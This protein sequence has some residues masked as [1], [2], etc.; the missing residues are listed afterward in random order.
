[1]STPRARWSDAEKKAVLDCYGVAT[2][3]DDFFNLLKGTLGASY[4]RR[5]AKAYL[6]FLN[7]SLLPKTD[8][9][10]PVYQSLCE[11]NQKEIA[12]LKA[13]EE[14][15]KLAAATPTPPVPVS[16]TPAAP[17]PVT[18]AVLGPV[19]PTP[20]TPVVVDGPG[21]E[22]LA[23][24]DPYNW[25]EKEVDVVPRVP[26][27]RAAP[28]SLFKDP[29]ADATLNGGRLPT[30]NE[31]L[32]AQEAEAFAAGATNRRVVGDYLATEEGR[33]AIA[34]SMV[35]PI[36]GV[37]ARVSTEPVTK[38]AVKPDP[39]AL[40]P[41]HY[42]ALPSKG[43]LSADDLAQVFG[44]ARTKVVDAI[45]FGFIPSLDG[46]TVRHLIA[47][48]IH[49]AMSEGHTFSE[50]C[51]LVNPNSTGLLPMEALIEKVDPETAADDQCAEV[52]PGFDAGKVT[53]QVDAWEVSGG[54]MN[55]KSVAKMAADLNA[56]GPP[57]TVEV[58]SGPPSLF[59][60]GEVF[61]VAQSVEVASEP[62][63]TVETGDLFK[64]FPL[65][66]VPLPERGAWA[67]AYDKDFMVPSVSK[68]GVPNG[69]EDVFKD[70]TATQVP[71]GAF[72]QYTLEAVRDGVI[73][74]AQGLDIL[75][76]SDTTKAL[77]AL[78]LLASGKITVVQCDR[79]L[80]AKSPPAPSAHYERPAGYGLPIPSQK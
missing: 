51:R 20:P 30:L 68:T 36:R 43:A 72:E 61:P 16:I 40:V 19:V 58:L 17:D 44:L 41:R 6:T 45:T 69:N 59:Q 64:E 57:T 75:N 31:A 55:P 24:S 47:Q 80:F 5:S 38:P 56:K 67:A 14:A 26:P 25:V 10:R 74:T 79:L 46:S 54:P 15:A 48:S 9:R 12:A 11:A 66:E 71:S 53:L 29:Q 49:D 4:F 34:A 50:A 39:T 2:N 32:A 22:T 28:P 7:E 62:A 78:S 35:Q 3:A 1:M 13:A 42:P 60:G 33:K 18:P 63:K 65:Q 23:L 70:M 21:V 77:W 76:P 27:G 37:G 8:P 73:T 52:V